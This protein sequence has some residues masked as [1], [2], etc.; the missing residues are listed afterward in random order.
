MELSLAKLINCLVSKPELITEV[1]GNVDKALSLGNVAPTNE[2]KAALAAALRMLG[3]Q[4]RVAGLAK[5]DNAIGWDGGG[6]LIVPIT[7]S[8]SN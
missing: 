8:P 7:V 4:D 3:T 2:N 5:L 6:E 1:N